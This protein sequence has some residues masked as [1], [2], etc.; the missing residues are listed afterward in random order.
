MVQHVTS[1][2]RLLVKTR[3]INDEPAPKQVNQKQ[4]NTCEKRLPSVILVGSMKSGT[5]A[6][7]EFMNHHPQIAACR[8]PDEPAYFTRHYDNHSFDWYRK[9]MPCSFPNQLTM[10][11]TPGYFYGNTTALR[12]KQMNENTKILMIFKDPVEVAIS[13][14]AMWK[15]HNDRKVRNKQFEDTVTVL[16]DKGNRII[17]PDSPIIWY[18]RY[19]HHVKAWVDIFGKDNVY[20]VD[21][22]AFEDDPWDELKPLEK[23]L[24]IK[25]F[26]R[27]EYFVFSKKK[28]KFCFLRKPLKAQ[29]LP[30]YKGRPH[31]DVSKDLIAL[32]KNYFKPYNKEFA[33]LMNR[34]FV[35]Q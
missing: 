27:K 24:K 19:V 23:H 34:T 8:N 3:N 1:S 33:Q 30:P 10:E 4:Q 12:I 22:S 32:L 5:S 35:W 31:P 11:K 25:D 18:C 7:I 17:D 6:L 26:Y 13:I 15:A 2:D 14:Y 28:G 16:D 9:L 21:G 29:C 20:A